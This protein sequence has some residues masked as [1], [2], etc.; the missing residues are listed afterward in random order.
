MFHH[1]YYDVVA[2][3]KCSL[4]RSDG[5][6]NWFLTSWWFIPHTNHASPSGSLRSPMTLSKKPRDNNHG[7][8]YPGIAWLPG[9]TLGSFFASPSY[10]LQHQS[11][12]PSLSR[13]K[14]VSLASRSKGTLFGQLN[15]R[16]AFN[17]T[18]GTSN[19][20]SLIDTDGITIVQNPIR[21]HPIFL[22]LPILGYFPWSQK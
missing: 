6:S 20:W 1:F 22:Y 7:P 19:D 17:M 21:L 16:H 3:V 14:I 9:R 12:N 8:H 18:R 4:S 5:D 2:R 10:P 13:L 11:V 15:V